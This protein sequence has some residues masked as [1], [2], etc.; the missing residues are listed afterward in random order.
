[1]AAQQE[2]ELVPAKRFFVDMLIRDIEL[3]DAI[4]DLLDNC[5][6]GAMR[7]GP[8]GDVEPDAP[9]YLGRF[10]KITLTADEFVIEDNCGGIG[11]DRALKSAF[12]MGRPDSEQDKDLPTVGVYGIGMK[13]AIFKLGRQA[14][15]SSFSSDGHFSVEIT[16]SWMQSDS[17]WK[18][19]ITTEQTA[20][21]EPGTKIYVSLLRDG[22]SRM[23]ADETGFITDLRKAIASYYSYIIEKGFE[24][25]VNGRKVICQHVSL[26]MDQSTFDTDEAVFPFVYESDYDGVNVSLAIGFYRNLPDDAEEE[27]ATRGPSSE[28]AGITIIC[29]DRVVVYAD[30]SRMTGWGEATVPQYHTQFVSIAGIVV[31]HSADASKLPL[32]TTKRGIDG[33]SELWLAVKDHVREGIKYFTDFTNKWKNAASERMEV[34]RSAKSVA[35]RSV[36]SLIP[37]DKWTNVNKGIKG[38]KFKP[39]LPLPKESDPMKHIRFQRPQSQ[40]SKVAE[41]LFEDSTTVPADVGAKC[42]DDVFRKVSK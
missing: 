25:F 18:I 32:T 24:V 28:L 27:E 3:K 38:R 12:R 35:P 36:A 13:R 5:V 42:F 7:S 8:V 39:A 6:D 33:N 29:N 10:A 20:L 30:K 37:Q 19:P 34:Q 1:M 9:P 16:P 2:V 23:F 4:L 15:V 11:I 14:V 40:I 31:F 26:L 22:N 17:D 21:T 41:Y